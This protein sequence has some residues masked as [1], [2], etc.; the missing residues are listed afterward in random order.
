MILE[1]P[2]LLPEGS[3]YTGE[4][5]SELLDLEPGARIQVL[6]PIYYDLFA[7]VVSCELLVRGR[8][9]A[10]MTFT[11]SRCGD[12][13]STRIEDSSFLHDYPLQ[14]GV[15]EVDMTG[16]LREL[17]LLQLPA[18]PL[19]S[20]SCKGV[21][22]RCGVNHNRESCDCRSMPFMTVWSE[23]DALKPERMEAPAQRRPARR[24]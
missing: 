3:R 22:P 20:D 7:Q 5:P 19:C 13:F 16:D 4:E 11:C 8:V 15:I 10:E 12:F 14:D 6:T 23:L 24:R 21:C 1:I 17:I 9:W 18:V 2:K